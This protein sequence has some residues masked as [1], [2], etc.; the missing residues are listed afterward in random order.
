MRR[1]PLESEKERGCE[2][3]ERESAN[4]ARAL[5]IVIERDLPPVVIK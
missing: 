1:T 5:V 4:F 2:F 3:L